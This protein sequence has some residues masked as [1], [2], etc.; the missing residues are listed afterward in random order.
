[1]FQDKKKYETGKQN[2]R[3]TGNNL[4]VFHRILDFNGYRTLQNKEK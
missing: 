2:P 1:M 4:Y 3:K